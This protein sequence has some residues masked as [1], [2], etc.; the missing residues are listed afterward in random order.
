M[1]RTL[2]AILASVSITV[3]LVGLLIIDVVLGRTRLGGRKAVRQCKQDTH[4][5]G[6]A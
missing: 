4:S 5:L 3:A 1:L 2:L 6:R